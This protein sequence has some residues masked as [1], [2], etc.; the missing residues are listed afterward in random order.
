M[1]P[2]RHLSDILFPPHPSLAECSPS[3]IILRVFQH[4]LP[5]WRSCRWLHPS[6]SAVIDKA[7]K[8]VLLE[9]AAAGGWVPGSPSVGFVSHAN[10]SSVP[11]PAQTD[12]KKCRTGKGSVMLRQGL[13]CVDC[14]TLVYPL[15][16]GLASAFPVDEGE[17]NL[18]PTVAPPLVLKW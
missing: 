4:L 1:D 13:S 7:W 5:Q 3:I 2:A 9:I 12:G 16:D 11:E 8:D 6:L 14:C 17:R 10:G 18:M 15:L